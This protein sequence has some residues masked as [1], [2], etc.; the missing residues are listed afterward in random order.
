MIEIHEGLGG[1]TIKV[2]KGKQIA[3]LECTQY[4]Y[5][6]ARGITWFDL[7]RAM[8][9]ARALDAAARQAR[10]RRRKSRRR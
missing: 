8:S 10:T 9:D 7:D 1:W 2:V 4:A 3:C 5:K 6:D